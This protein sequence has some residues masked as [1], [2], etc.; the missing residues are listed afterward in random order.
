MP[1][2]RKG[3]VWSARDA[4]YVFDGVEKLLGT[5]EVEQGDQPEIRFGKANA[6]IVPDTITGEVTVWDNATNPPAAT[7]EVI[8][9]VW[10]VWL[11][12]QQISAGKEVILYRSESTA[13]NWHVFWAEYETPSISIYEDGGAVV[14][15]VAPGAT[16]RIPLTLGASSANPAFTI[17]G[18]NVLEAIQDVVLNYTL[19]NATTYIAT[20][21]NQ[22]I[23][24]TA[25]IVTV[26]GTPTI[27]DIPLADT[28]I[29]PRAGDF[30][31]TH[32]TPTGGVVFTAGDQV[33]FEFTN[34]ASSAMDLQIDG[35]ILS[36][37]PAG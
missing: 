11:S 36:W 26:A 6:D 23:S 25:N 13:G 12:D 30:Q 35:Y 8:T 7:A 19:D 17:V 3:S 34:L 2:Y 29:S 1:K 14:P 32:S 37:R 28:F 16:Q 21:N 31:K 22:D 33:A 9:D 24:I 18:G 27:V 5:Y 4:Q 10:Y 15:V 20:G